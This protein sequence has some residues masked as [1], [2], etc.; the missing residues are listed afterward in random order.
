MTATARL[1]IAITDRNP[2]VREFLCRELSGLGHAASSFAS[3]VSLLEALCGPKPPQVLVLDPEVA[4][5]GLSEVARQLK[6][7][8]GHVTV[9][10]HVFEGAEPQPEFDG[11]LVVEKQPD[12]GTL[13]A[14]LKTL[15]AQSCRL[16][17]AEAASGLRRPQ[18]K[19]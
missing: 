3:I 19:P 1:D 18:E 7:H 4:G 16:P 9:V 17:G 10:L 5:T 15:A 13:K 11:A 14:V 6:N 12:M 8:P 2:H